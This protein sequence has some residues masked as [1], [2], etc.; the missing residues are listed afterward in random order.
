MYDTPKFGRTNDGF[1]LHSVSM[2]G[3]GIKHN[4]PTGDGESLSQSLWTVTHDDAYVKLF[5]YSTK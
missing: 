3:P 5:Y 4:N 1:G 2:F